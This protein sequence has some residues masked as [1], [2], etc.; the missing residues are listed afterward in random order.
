MGVLVSQG[1]TADQYESGRLEFSQT[2]YWRV[3]EVNAP[4]D[5]TIYRGP[6]WSFQVEALASTIEKITATASVPSEVGM[7][8]ENTVNGSG[9]DAND[10]HSMDATAMWLSG[11]GTVPPLWI[12]Y[13]FDKIH[14]LHEM[15]I[16]NYNGEFEFIIGFGVQDVT[17]QVSMD[18]TAWTALSDTKVAPGPEAEGY[19]HNTTIPFDSVVAQHVRLMIQS[20]WGSLDQFGLSEVRFLQIPTHARV[21]VPASG[22]TDVGF[23]VTLTWCPG[24]EA[25]QHRVYFGADQKAV[26]EGTALLDTVNLR[27]VQPPA[28]DLGTTYFWRVEEVN[29]ASSPGLWA[30]DV[31]SFTTARFMTMDDFE[32]Y[33]DECNKI[34]YMWKGGSANGA[35]AACN[36]QAYAGN[37]TGSVVGNANAPYAEKTIVNSGNQSMPLSYTNTAGVLTSIDRKSVV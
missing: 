9:L 10:L 21:P 14:Q 22:Q 2:Y 13:D 32:A 1:Q 16:W 23:D 19:A 36:V 28:L 12:Q 11:L 20:N 33:D 34:Y 37:G 35:N 4:S 29:E 26:A 18:G 27:R 5:S 6:V 15:W 30:G 17:V 3:D 8:P 24:R 25:V 7:G 31:W